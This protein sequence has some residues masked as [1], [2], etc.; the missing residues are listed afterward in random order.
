MSAPNPAHDLR[1]VAPAL[2]TWAVMGW[3]T[4]TR[5]WEDLPLWLVSAVLVASLA[6]MWIIRLS[7]TSWRS[8][9]NRLFSVN[10]RPPRTG[11]AVLLLGTVILSLCVGLTHAQTRQHPTLNTWA[12]QGKQV[13]VLASISADPR[14][15]KAGP[16]PELASWRLAI[17]VHEV[18]TTS[19][20]YTGKLPA[21]LIAEAPKT[22]SPT[23]RAGCLSSPAVPSNQGSKVS[24]PSPNH[25][26][27]AWACLAV[28][29]QISFTAKLSPGE[30]ARGSHYLLRAGTT[31]QAELK[32][33]AEPAWW[34]RTSN[35][36]RDALLQHTQH[37]SP[38]GQG[39]VPGIAIGDTSALPEDLAEAMKTVSL[40]HITAVSGAHFAI[41][42]TLLLGICLA[43][44]IPRGLIVCTVSL[45]MAG[46]VLLVRPEASVLRA[47]AMGAV[48]LIAL[49]LRRPSSALPALATAVIG[50]LM[51]DPWLARSYGFALST[52]ATAG[53]VI[54]TGPIARRL[55]RLPNWLAHA[56]AVPA[57][58]Q[59]ACAP[60]IIML[61][62]Q[63]SPYAVIAN[64]AAAPLVIAPT[65]MGVGA[66]LSAPAA[67]ALANL[68]VHGSEIFTGWIAQIAYITARWP[69]A[70]LPW[71]PGAAGAFT[72]AAV[73]LALAGWLVHR[74]TK[75]GNDKYLQPLTWGTLRARIQT[76]ST[77]TQ[78]AFLAL[79]L[80]LVCTATTWVTRTASVHLQAGAP[81]D[82]QIIACDVGQGTAIIIRTSPDAAPSAIVIDTGPEPQPILECLADLRVTKIDLLAISHLHADHVGGAAAILKQYPVEQLLTNPLAEPDHAHQYLIGEAQAANVPIQLADSTSHGPGW[83]VLWPTPEFITGYRDDHTLHFTPSNQD[84]NDAS[85]VLHVNQAGINL[86]TLGDL[87]TTGQA[88]L[89]RELQRRDAGQ[90]AGSGIGQIDVVQVAHHGSRTQDGALA[91]YLRP[92]VSLISAGRDNDYGHPAASTV[93][94]YAQYGG[95][96]STHACG[97]LYLTGQGSL[98]LYAEHPKERECGNLEE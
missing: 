7:L 31:S 43:V 81:H 47:A 16:N 64:L 57:A 84:L 12:E 4:T 82:W 45:A 19:H 6:G 10:R 97:R 27:P 62:P 53:L 79:S 58:A 20:S 61:S 92:K 38:Q 60:L 55:Q 76:A 32:I 29:T 86:I 98:S 28:G 63:I 18:S 96:F 75:P 52:L 67:P 1:L 3:T 34:W 77:A 25:S 91:G 69:G 88:G 78:L 50:L 54:L 13:Q 36:L 95:V 66:A 83:Q 46:F 11:A 35:T 5:G 15:V 71:I 74:D 73:H 51:L 68:L 24:E 42:S 48:G 30:P 49:T 8:S 56:I 40:T 72:L 85:L 41:M 94:M 21:Q 80:L 2:G 17:T 89:L 59:L 39:L 37:L 87:E 90:G 26:A 70:N 33:I 9:T 93:K 23:S 14:P 65:I 22:S 44:K